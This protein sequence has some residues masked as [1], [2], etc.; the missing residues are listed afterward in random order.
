[1]KNGMGCAAD[2]KGVTIGAANATKDGGR[3]VKT[4][5]EPVVSQEGAR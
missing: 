5:M 1:M 2:E 3:T 4:S